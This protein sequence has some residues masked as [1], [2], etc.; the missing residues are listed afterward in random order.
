[1]F[2]YEECS[3]LTISINLFLAP[4]KKTVILQN[5]GIEKFFWKKVNMDCF[6]ILVVF[7]GVNILHYVFSFISL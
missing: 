6:Y 7:F 1:M 5:W 3:A 4:F 2:I